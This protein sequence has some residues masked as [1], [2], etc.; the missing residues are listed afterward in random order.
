MGYLNVENNYFG[1]H[2][3]P[4]TSM[5]HGILP[6]VGVLILDYMYEYFTEVSA[7]PDDAPFPPDAQ[8]RLQLDDVPLQLL[9]NR[10]LPL[11]PV[12]VAD[13]LRHLGHPP[14]LPAE[15]RGQL[16]RAA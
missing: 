9:L 1:E 16:E 2:C 7:A 14:R 10:R 4:P 12:Q 8:V 11:Y 5:K 3:N 6:T 13:V 15:V